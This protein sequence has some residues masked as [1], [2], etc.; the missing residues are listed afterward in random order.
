MAH[1]MVNAS[2][3]ER[4]RETRPGAVLHRDGTRLGGA[5]ECR[6]Q[7]RQR[8]ALRGERTVIT[9]GSTVMTHPFTVISTGISG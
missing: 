9:H 3:S 2:S 8:A 1:R 4:S 6:L 7:I 5:L